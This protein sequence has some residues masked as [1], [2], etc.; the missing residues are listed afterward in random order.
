V[1]NTT[2]IPQKKM[3]KYAYY[4]NVAALIFVA[5]LILLIAHSLVYFAL[6]SFF[7]ITSFSA[8]TM[9]IASLAI[10]G[11]SFFASTLLA[12]W[13]E[14]IFTRFYYYISCFWIGLLTNLIL[15][16]TAVSLILIATSYIY[17]SMKLTALGIAAP[18]AALAF[19]CWGAWNA[20]QLQQ[21]N[22]AVT[23]PNL[24]ENWRGKKIVQIS[25]VHL[26]HI[27][28]ESFF[29]KVIQ[30]VNS[31]KPD[32][33]VITGDLFDGMDGNLEALAKLVDTIEASQGIYFITGNHETYLGTRQVFTA[34]EKTKVRLLHDEVVDLQG[35]KLI[36]IDY[37]DL[38]EKKNLPSLL[39][40]LRKDFFG[41]PR[42]NRSRK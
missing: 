41:Q 29:E 40:N 15:A 42:T 30:R 11:L 20:R 6:I 16:I 27:L 31:Q 39:E 33:V 23:I 18:I 9:L 3:N 10:L 28:G 38:S 7:S 37:P 26:G 5:L 34:L 36:G 21:K 32:L 22:I 2:T 35:L 19:S 17:P 1:E 8:K 4:L 12:H 13:R 14:N 25:D 24:P